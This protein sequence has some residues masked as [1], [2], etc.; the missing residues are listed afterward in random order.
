MALHY[1]ADVTWPV[2]AQRD[3]VRRSG[4]L[5]KQALH[6]LHG[7]DQALTLAA[8][9]AAKHRRDLVA[10]ARIEQRMRLAA[11]RRERKHAGARILRRALSAQQAAALEALQQAAEVACVE[12]QVGGQLARAAF[13]ALADLADQARLGQRIRAAEQPRAQGAD[14]ACVESVET[15]H[16]IDV[17][18]GTL[19]QLL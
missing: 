4:F 12:I 7:A 16:R 19:F 6:R 14:T 17:H 15:A 8:R 18:R 11:L 2:P 13:A 1:P 3:R 10:R 5:I 9:Q